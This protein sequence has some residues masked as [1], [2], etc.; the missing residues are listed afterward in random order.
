MGFR[1]FF[2]VQD[3]PDSPDYRQPLSIHRFEV[4]DVTIV[5]ERWD[6]TAGTW[7]DNP[8]MI[9]FTG[10]GGATDYREVDVAEAE[11]FLKRLGQNEG[12]PVATQYEIADEGRRQTELDEAQAA[13]YDQDRH[14]G[15][16][17]IARATDS[18]VAA[19]RSFAEVLTGRGGEG[20]GHHGHAGRPGEVGGSIAG[21]GGGKAEHGRGKPGI[22]IGV[23]RDAAKPGMTSAEMNGKDILQPS[24]AP[25]RGTVMAIDD[26]RIPETVYHMTT[27]LS[28]LSESNEISA[29]GE[30]GLEGD[31]RDQMVS[32]TIDE[33]I[34]IG[35]VSDTRLVATIAREFGPIEPE[36]GNDRTEWGLA[37]VDRLSKL[38]TAAKEADWKWE[39]LHPLQYKAH[40]LGDIVRA[41]FQFRSSGAQI[42]N[43][44]F[45]G[46]IKNMAK[47]DPAEI[48]YVRI[49]RENLDT[50]ALITDFDLDNSSGLKEIRLYGDVPLAGAEFVSKSLVF[51][52]GP[53]SGHH[54]HS[55][56]PGEVGGSAPGEGDGTRG[57]EGK[58]YRGG[59]IVPLTMAEQGQI[60]QALDY[61][62]EDFD[63]A[64]ALSMSG[65]IPQGKFPIHDPDTG[66]VVWLT[67]GRDPVLSHVEDQF[68][69]SMIENLTVIKPDG[70]LVFRVEGNEYAIPVTTDD[71]DR[72]HELALSG[73]TIIMTHNHPG[74][75]ESNLRGSF[76]NTDVSSGLKYGFS[77]IRATVS[78]GTYYMKFKDQPMSAMRT[79]AI[80]ETAQVALDTELEMFG[81]DKA[82]YEGNIAEASE[83]EFKSYT[84]AVHLAWKS[85]A[86]IYSDQLEY[87]FEP[88]ETG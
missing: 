63:P 73:E 76:S 65:E 38:D 19:L 33:K 62:G 46:E 48:G 5:T 77:E 20:S 35:L 88:K 12:R 23:P 51:K 71:T 64:N 66:E 53:G 16:N 80:M 1:Y 7:V 18:L 45:F 24:G 9:D 31:P 39:G 82:V 41:Y 29:G 81:V 13:L 86:E 75:G 60:Q 15:R 43:P 70:T 3:N 28:G 6:T 36:Y 58:S 21:E 17:I 11:R 10:I 27:S 30:G 55:G 4:T 25:I 22:Y 49:P 59:K 26:P 32:M 68:R 57:D 37:V 83:E 14:E 79:F 56:R 69:D 42:N 72:I 8:E 47:Y 44:L 50:G 40:G 84:E 52:G 74:I 78:D 85:V 67:G 2:R 61:F 54:G 87:G 34:A